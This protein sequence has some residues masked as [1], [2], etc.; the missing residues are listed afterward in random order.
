MSNVV[1]LGYL[2]AAVCFILALRGLSSPATARQG[3]RIGIAGM[4]VGDGRAAFSTAGGQLAVILALSII[5]ICWVWA[6]Q[7]MRL[8]EEERVFGA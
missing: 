8:P 3:N 1:A 5:T 4:A 2:A 7:L 6:S